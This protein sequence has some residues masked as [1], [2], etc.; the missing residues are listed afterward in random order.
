MNEKKFDFMIYI[1]RANIV[2]AF[3]LSAYLPAQ[4]QNEHTIKKKKTRT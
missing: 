2:A 4:K 1:L 3:F